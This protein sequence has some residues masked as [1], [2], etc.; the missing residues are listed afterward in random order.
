MVFTACVLVSAPLRAQVAPSPEDS[1]AAILSAAEPVLSE[2]LEIL[3]NNRRYRDGIDYSA[4]VESMLAGILREQDDPYAAVV[5]LSGIARLGDSESARTADVG[6][7]LDSDPYGRLLVASV[8]PDSPAENRG[9]RVRDYLLRIDGIN[10]AGMTPWELAPH[11]ALASRSP[12]RLVV[13]SPGEEPRNLTLEPGDY[14]VQTVTLRIGRRR[15]GRWQDVP[16]GNW[17][18]LAVHAYLG[19]TTEREW[20]DAIREIWASPSVEGIILDLR[21]NG[22]G[23]NGGIRT[24]GDFFMP[25]DELVRFR[26]LFG[27]EGW[28]E[29]VYNTAVPRARLI[30]YPVVVLVNENTASLAEMVAAT[31]QEQRQVPVFGTRTYGKGTTQSWVTV[32]E[33]Y[34]VHLTTAEWFTPGGKSVDGVGLRPDLV[35]PGDPLIA[36]LSYLE[37]R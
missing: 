30:A 35:V 36:A 1:E 9:V 27:D 14:E 11:L 28:E 6:L 22:G 12:V 7:I 17:A 31:L 20:T 10:T 21:D 29:V 37:D 3:Q 19:E 24:L 15:F 5:E 32:G 2:L 4:T 25:G 34:A 26:S 23:D 13:Q 18:W 16:E 33:R 8:F